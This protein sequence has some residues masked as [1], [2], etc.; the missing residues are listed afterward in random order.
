L[1]SKYWAPV[2]RVDNVRWG[3]RNLFSCS[4]AALCRLEASDDALQ[5]RAAQMLFRPQRCTTI[6][7]RLMAGDRETLDLLNRDDGAG[8]LGRLLR[9]AGAAPRAVQLEC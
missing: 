4:C 5:W 2:G 8:E 9:Q 1:R 7:G 6:E 3:D